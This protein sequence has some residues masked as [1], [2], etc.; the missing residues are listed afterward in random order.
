MVLYISIQAGNVIKYWNGTTWNAV[1]AVDT[2]N[3]QLTDLL[4][5]WQSHYNKENIWHKT[6][7]DTQATM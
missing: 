4:L 6:L 1:E 5:Q 3:L 7:E 2:S